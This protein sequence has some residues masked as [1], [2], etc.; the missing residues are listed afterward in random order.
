MPTPTS[1]VLGRST[2]SSSAA[3]ARHRT[4]IGGRIGARTEPGRRCIP[5][6][7]ARLLWAASPTCRSATIT[8]VRADHSR[9][10][11]AAGGQKQIEASE[12]I[13]V[14]A[15]MRQTLRPAERQTETRWFSV[16]APLH[17]FG[18]VPRGR[19]R[20][21]MEPSRWF[22]RA[23]AR[24]LVPAG[25]C[26]TEMI[27]SV[28]WHT[29]QVESAVDLVPGKLPCGSQCLTIA[30]RQP[31]GKPLQM[32]PGMT[33]DREF[34]ALR[35]RLDQKITFLIRRWSFDAEVAAEANLSLWRHHVS[36]VVGEDELLRRLDIDVRRYVRHEARQRSI[37]DRLRTIAP[38]DD[39]EADLD[40]LIASLDAHRAC[41]V[42][43]IP[44]RARPWVDKAMHRSPGPITAAERMY[45][46]RWGARAR[47]ALARSSGA[48]ADPGSGI[49]AQDRPPGSNMGAPDGSLRPSRR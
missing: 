5:N 36:G 47:Q 27:R 46:V 1:Y 16:L 35:Q 34:T 32:I 8:F 38:V 48:K 43:D 42:L 7:S 31:P 14:P 26:R 37:P 19:R 28:G 23:M 30:G 18:R 22:R 15:D 24:R 21:E 17:H 45:G 6:R 49:G 33:N 4:V 12:Q 44:D 2:H 20:A 9:R 3:S 41:A 10:S 11:L 13:S 40:R 25:T 29:P 39:G